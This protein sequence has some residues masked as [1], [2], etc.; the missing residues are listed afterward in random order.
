MGLTSEKICTSSHASHTNLVESLGV[1]RMVHD[2]SL[3][4]FATIH[5]DLEP[6]IVIVLHI[7][8][9]MTIYA[10]GYFRRHLNRLYQIQIAYKC[11]SKMFFLAFIKCSAK[12]S[13]SL[14]RLAG[15]SFSRTKRKVK[16]RMIQATGP[17]GAFYAESLLHCRLKLPQ[18]LIK[19]A[20]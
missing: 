4:P 10:I 7:S 1:L 9:S 13:T 5:T 11:L 20:I 3:S 14:R 8:D 19:I 12:I 15:K 17:G 18:L 2:N 6:A 16:S